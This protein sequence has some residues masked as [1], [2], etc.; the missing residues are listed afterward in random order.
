MTTARQVMEAQVS[1]LTGGYWCSVHDGDQRALALLKEHYSYR[2]RAS[3]Q[4]RGS[5]TFIGAGEKIVLLTLDC[6]ALFGWHKA[7]V[8]RYSGEEGISCTVFRNTGP[9]LSS[10]LISEADELAWVRWPEESRH[11]T[12]VNARKIQSTNPGYCFKQAGWHTCG[13]SKGGL[14]ILERVRP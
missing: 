4:P 9:V 11:F 12:Y 6:L 3:G 14:V 8:K 10:T 7:T 13:V 2:R 5:P 1:P